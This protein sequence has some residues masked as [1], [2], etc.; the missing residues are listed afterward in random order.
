MQSQPSYIR[1]TGDFLTKLQDVQQPVQGEEGHRP[2]IFCMDVAKLYPSVPRCEGVAACR[3][4]LE[5][6]S[7][8]SI[9]TDELL[10]II[11]LVLDNN[12]FQLGD[13]KNYVQTDGIAIGSRLGRNFACTYMGA[14]ENELLTRA[15]F[16]PLKWYRFIDDIW[17]IWT[18]GEEALRDFHELANAIHPKINVELRVSNTSIELLD[19]EVM[20]S[21]SGYISTSLFTKPT[22]ARAYLHY[23]S[24]HP[25]CMKRA[26][27]KGLG[28]RLKRICSKQSDYQH[29]R[30]NLISRL[31][32][33]GYPKGRVIHELGKVD[34]MGREEILGRRSK[35]RSVK[36][37]KGFPW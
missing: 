1:D 33:R 30:E 4:A 25:P 12:N 29:H 36:E 24:D 16:R 6:R 23:D 22:D 32:E 27:P 5:E 15:N 7:E 2:L 13:N 19:V 26:I 11:E 37:G 35:K 3:D 17:G 14:W 8:G 20:L 10:E 31:C 9:P 18:H 28:M 34:R 21:D